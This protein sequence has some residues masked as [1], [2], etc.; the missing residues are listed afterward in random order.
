[1][2]PTRK[3]AM[4]S[5]ISMAAGTLPAAMTADTAFEAVSTL[6]KTASSVLTAYDSG[7]SLTIALVTMPSVPSDPTINPVRS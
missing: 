7:V 5:I 3:M 6:G 4:L 2:N 1:M